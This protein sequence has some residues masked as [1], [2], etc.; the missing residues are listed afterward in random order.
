MI[1][2]IKGH[3]NRSLKK[4][5]MSIVGIILILVILNSNRNS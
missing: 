1:T 5:K 4:I 2:V 3:F